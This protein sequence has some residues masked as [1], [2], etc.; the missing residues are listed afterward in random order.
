MS[1]RNLPQDY[2]NL[3]K[4][5]GFLWLGPEVQNS[6][7][8]TNWKCG[9][10]HVWSSRYGDIQQGVG[11]PIC[12]GN[13]PKTA[14][15]FNRLS[16]KRGFKWIGDKAVG[17]HVKTDW[18]CKYGHRWS[19]RY[20]DI[21]RGSGCPYCSGKARKNAADYETIAKLFG[22]C[23]LGNLP[24]NNATNTLWECGKG[25]QW[26]ST[27]S[28]LQ[29]GHGCPF[30]AGNK[31]KTDQDYELLAKKKRIKWLGSTVTGNKSI[32]EWKCRNDHVW[33]ARYND[34]Q[35]GSGCPYC[36][37]NAPKVAA[38]YHI[39][40]KRRKFHW[41]G[42]LP[43][44]TRM[45]TGWECKKGHI[46]EATY[47]SI[48][49]G[50]NCP[51]CASN[52]P[53]TN[54]DYYELARERNITW[55]GPIGRNINQ[56]T[57]WSCRSGHK[58]KASYSNVS[59]GTNCP[60]C[61]NE[62]QKFKSSDYQKLAK[63]RGFVWIGSE[64][65]GVSNKTQWKCKKGHTWF[66]PYSSI[67]QGRGCPLCGIESRSEKRR[68][69]PEDYL[70]L[71]DERGFIWLGPEVTNNRVVTK[72]QCK[73]KHQWNAAYHDIQQGRLCPFCLDTV[74]GVLV[75]TQQRK[76]CDMLKGE[77]NIPFGRYRIDV[78]MQYKNKPIA[79]EYDAWF[80]HGGKQDFDE[81][82]NGE[83]ISAGWKVLRV[84]SNQLLPS[85]EQLN[86]ALSR[87]TSDDDYVK[88]ILKDWGKGVTKVDV[89]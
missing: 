74:H 81:T 54:S 20:H 27:Y 33:K 83:L 28:T 16:K 77:L 70:S 39:L 65:N 75:S 41:L 3:A 4:G 18:E 64:I 7:T 19:A 37:G 29:Q 72:W 59:R 88:I 47:R 44:N 78:A 43:D 12:S 56:P 79:I 50:S 45:N 25:H 55:H 10:G 42:P 23:W 67:Q 5:R 24:K 9:N 51:T 2:Q 32:T 38:D 89:T 60:V 68:Y 11:C 69:K 84:K 13:I 87:L 82:R 34:I 85:V 71:A 26:Y 57:V 36:Y 30:C 66:A 22:F 48:Q 31:A 73:K 46:W 52:A 14:S 49:Q 1:K 62:S 61:A 40:A 53:K 86:S 21:Q 17:I 58:W 6:Q 80:W 8:K 76:L 63:E 15:D 35:R